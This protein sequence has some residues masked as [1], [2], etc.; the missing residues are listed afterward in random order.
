MDTAGLLRVKL[1]T[2]LPGGVA[3]AAVALDSPLPGLPAIEQALT[4][5]MSAARRREFAAGRHCARQALAAAG[6]TNAD[7]AIARGPHR[8]PLWPA[9]STG[10]ISHT[11]TLAAAI[12]ARTDHNRSVGLDIEDKAAVDDTLLGTLFAGAEYRRIAAL[13]ANDRGLAATLAFSAKESVY[14]CVHPLLGRFIDYPEVEILH[15][16]PDGHFACR[17]PGNAIPRSLCDR[18]Q[19]RHGRIAGHVITLAWIP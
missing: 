16:G 18:L 1:E 3:V 11:R 10:S 7:T 15:A 9:G 14:K 5:G 12:A 17:S 8:E 19:G 6:A 4:P 13:P 2:L